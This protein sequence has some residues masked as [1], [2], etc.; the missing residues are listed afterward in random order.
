MDFNLLLSSPVARGSGS[1]GS[2]SAVTVTPGQCGLLMN[3]LSAAP[4]PA[5]NGAQGAQVSSFCQKKPAVAKAA[6]ARKRCEAAAIST[7]ELQTMWYKSSNAVAVRERGGRQ[8]FQIAL[9]GASRQDLEG[10]AEQCL[11]KL[12]E[13]GTVQETK[14]WAEEQ[15]QS[16]RGWVAT[17]E[18]AASSSLALVDPPSCEACAGAEEGEEEEAA[19]DSEA[20]S[21][22]EDK[23]EVETAG[24]QEIW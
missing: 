12:R 11:E 19:E 16:L 17:C 5:G 23:A 6:G 9:K 10:L 15:K 1:A 4:R 14:A 20:D 18:K 24:P 21:A 2:G 22:E 13:G 8:L 7:A 3:L